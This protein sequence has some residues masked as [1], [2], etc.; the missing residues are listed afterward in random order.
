MT[1]SDSGT[2]MSGTVTED[3]RDDEM[4]GIDFANHEDDARLLLP[5]NAEPSF[6]T[7][8]N[9]D[10]SK[11]LARPFARSLVPLTHLLASLYS[12]AL[13]TSQL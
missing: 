1:T 6:R 4:D 11:P 13:L 8:K 10:V 5:P 3:D 2:E 9:G 12:C 7:A